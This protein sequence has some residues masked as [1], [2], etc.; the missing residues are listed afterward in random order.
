MRL[1]VDFT[2][3]AIFAVSIKTQLYGY[4]YVKDK[5]PAILLTLLVLAL[6]LQKLSTMRGVVIYDFR[7]R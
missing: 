7:K 5:N 4:F 2:W 6:L 3:P 1:A